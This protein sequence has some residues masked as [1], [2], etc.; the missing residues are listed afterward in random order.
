MLARLGVR[1]IVACSYGRNGT[2][3]PATTG[4]ASSTLSAWLQNREVETAMVR[5]SGRLQ[6]AM[7][8]T[9]LTRAMRQL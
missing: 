8:E 6:R 7:V 9:V 1:R 4:F 3:Y 5:G 2:H